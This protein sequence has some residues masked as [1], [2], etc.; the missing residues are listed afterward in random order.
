[1]I[2]LTLICYNN[3]LGRPRDKESEMAQRKFYVKLKIRRK[4][5]I[6]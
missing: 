1:M 4:R 2:P 6:S 3:K 5:E